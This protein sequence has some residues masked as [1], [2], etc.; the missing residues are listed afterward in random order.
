[1]GLNNAAADTTATTPPAPAPAKPKLAATTA[2]H[3]A[4]AKLA[5]AK[6]AEARHPASPVLKPS[7]ADSRGAQDS[8]AAPPKEELVSGA[9]PIISAS[10]FESRFSAM[11]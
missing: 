9:Q 5:A 10:S 11:K 1:M 3:T 6:P 7:I 8:S 4:A 2:R